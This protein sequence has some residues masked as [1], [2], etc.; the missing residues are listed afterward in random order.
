MLNKSKN[1]MLSRKGSGSGLAPDDLGGIGETAPKN[2]PTWETSSYSN[3]QLGP[4]NQ[5]HQFTK[6]KKSSSKE[7]EDIEDIGSSLA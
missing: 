1:K 2:S 7:G 3:P 5:N 4:L 6:P